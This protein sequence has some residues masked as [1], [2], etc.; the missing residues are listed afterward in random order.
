MPRFPS[1]ILRW[2][3]CGLFLI[4]ALTANAAEP[5]KQAS[6]IPL[7]LPQAQFAGYYMAAEKGIYLKHGI[8][9]SIIEGGPGRNPSEYLRDGRA[10]FA[11]LWLTATATLVFMDLFPETTLV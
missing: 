7:W 5:V 2:L 4:F 8:D 3:S 9:L 1:L 10:D 11:A 6:F